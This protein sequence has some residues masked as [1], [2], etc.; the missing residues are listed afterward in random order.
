MKYLDLSFDHLF[1]ARDQLKWFPWVGSE[2]SRSAVKTMILGESVYRWSKGDAFDERYALTSGLRVTHSNHALDFDRNSRYVRN[3][4][5]AIFHRRN[6]SDA[7]KQVLW[8]SVVYH[9]LVLD[10]MKSAKHRPK[11]EQ[12]ETGW[13]AA[14]DLFD[15]LGIEQC[16]VFGVESINGLRS[17]AREGKLT[18]SIKRLP[19]K[20]G[21]FF[22]K[23][24]TVQTRSGTVVKLAFVRHP[25]SFFSWRKWAPIVREGLDW[26]F[27]DAQPRP[28]SNI[29][30]PATL[31]A[32]A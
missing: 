32:A 30:L 17:A 13:H 27:C 19:T 6:P 9:N 22:P 3:I 7:Q 24:G 25:S 12:Y 5:R 31:T 8:S 18:C 21:R 14:L 16:L 28:E 1:E 26:K 2:F 10:A 23:V 4:E 11:P 15:L 29:A 20:V